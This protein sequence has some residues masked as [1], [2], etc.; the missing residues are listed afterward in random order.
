MNELLLIIFGV[1]QIGDVLTTEA[2]INKGGSE[3]NPVMRALFS[4]FGMHNVLVCKAVLLICLGV[5]LTEIM[6]EAL[7]VL[8]LMYVGVVGWNLNQWRQMK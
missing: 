1:L 4:R 6:P 8:I 3:L 2:I 5:V 7:I